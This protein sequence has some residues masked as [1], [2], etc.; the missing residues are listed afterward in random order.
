MGT[1][2]LQL[3]SDDETPFGVIAQLTTDILK[4][5]IN[6]LSEQNKKRVAYELRIRSI[7]LP[8]DWK[9]TN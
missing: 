1:A 5:H 6:L 9:L 3:I 4:E 2:L 8:E 7:E